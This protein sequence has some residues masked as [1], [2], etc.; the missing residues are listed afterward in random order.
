M[1]VKTI[2]MGEIQANSH[3]LIDEKSGDAAVI[4][5]GECSGVL[6]Q[7]LKDEKIKN[8]RY[9][10]LTHGHFDHIDGVYAF[11][12]NYPQVP[13]CIHEF[14]A[15]CLEDDL[16]SLRRGFGLPASEGKIHADILLHDGDLLPFGDTEIKVIHTPGHTKGG[17]TYLIDDML[18]TGD[19][20]F[21]LTVGRTD[22]PGGDPS[23]LN[24][25][26]NRLFDLPGDY[27]VYTGHNRS[28]TLDRERTG[29]IYVRRRKRKEKT[30]NV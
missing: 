28:T 19:T 5:I 7:S 17:V 24:D 2:P 26:I 1:I 6:I 13:V 22:L 25:S 21:C 10:L 30:G 18:F 12:K 8:I 14:D 9:V 29:N 16:V 4:D 27:K 15:K 20:L 23:E 11:K 3:I